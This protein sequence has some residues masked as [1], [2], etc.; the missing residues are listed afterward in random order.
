[1]RKALNKARDESVALK[2]S[3]EELKADHS[4]FKQEKATFEMIKKELSGQI[5]SLKKALEKEKE[6]S[7]EWSRQREVWEHEK[8]A[9]ERKLGEEKDK[10]RVTLAV[11]RR[12][13]SNRRSRV[14]LA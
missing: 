6:K 4:K 10:H 3:L 7:T 2:Q 9:L 11:W 14:C 12:S 1:M 13:G 8:L 5:Q